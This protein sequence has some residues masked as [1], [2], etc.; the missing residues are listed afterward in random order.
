MNTIELKCKFFNFL[1]G[2]SKPCDRCQSYLYLHGV[3]KI[4]YTDIIDGINVL[5]E[6]KRI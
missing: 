6:M 2:N 4:K 3:K 1:L 5:C